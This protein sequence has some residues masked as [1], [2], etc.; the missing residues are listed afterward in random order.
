MYFFDYFIRM[1]MEDEE[2]CCTAGIPV[3]TNSNMNLASFSLFLLVVVTLP[4]IQTEV[5]FDTFHPA[6]VHVINV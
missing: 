1:L 6:E 5:I 4:A 2:S 3:R